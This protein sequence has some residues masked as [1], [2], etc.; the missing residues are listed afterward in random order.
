MASIFDLLDGN[1]ID[2]PKESAEDLLFRASARGDDDRVRELVHSSDINPL[3]QVN[4]FNSLHIASRK[5]HITVIEEL[6]RRF[7]SLMESCTADGRHSLMLAA[8]EGKVTVMRHV[9]EI[10]PDLYTTSLIGAVDLQG[11]SSL[12]YAAWAGSLDCV[13]F[14]V[15]NCAENMEIIFQR[16]NEGLTPLQYAVAGNH[17]E[18]TSYLSSFTSEQ[19]EQYESNAG[20]TSIHRAAMYGSIE[21]LKLL[22]DANKISPHAFTNNGS[23]ALHLACQRGHLAAAKMLIERCGSEIDIQNDYGITPLMHACIG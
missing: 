18:V 20:L 6:L 9:K 3:A 2:R 14:L 8:F 12:H 21:S 17:V 16:N 4:G 10:F 15:N 11:N 1:T 5:G 22:L 13:Q 23:A 7:P 19:G